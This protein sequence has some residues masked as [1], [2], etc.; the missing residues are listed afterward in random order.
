MSIVDAVV[1]EDRPRPWGLW[2]TLGW[3]F[4]VLGVYFAAQTVMAV[5]A[6]LAAAGEP[7]IGLTFCVA[8]WISNPVCVA[9]IAALA[10]GRRGFSV[11]DY[12]ALRAVPWQRL[13]R[14]IGGV[15]LFAVAADVLTFLLGRNVVPESMLEI[16]TSV[17]WPVLLWSVVLLAAPVFEEVFFRGFMFRGVQASRLGS[18]GAIALT[19]LVWTGMHVQYDWYNLL[20]VFAGGV[21][22]GVAR[23]RM[24]SVYPTIA[25]HSVWNLIATLEVWWYVRSGQV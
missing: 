25:M 2:A 21:L 16:Y 15:I 4:L 6:T 5:A 13:A 19:S 17:R 3:S 1:V 20:I 11:T 14:W 12:L 22:L 18:S 23:A 10:A 7:S 9:L 24:G 8:T